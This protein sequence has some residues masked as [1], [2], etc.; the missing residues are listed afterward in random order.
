MQTRATTCGRMALLLGFSLCQGGCFAFLAEDDDSE[1]EVYGPTAC[2]W[3]E[4]DQPPTMTLHAVSSTGT[5]SEP[6][7]VRVEVE[8]DA[9]TAVDLAQIRLSLEVHTGQAQPGE[10]VSF[11]LDGVALE[12]ALLGGS[13]GNSAEL[14]ALVPAER[15][16]DGCTLTFLVTGPEPKTIPIP[17]A[18]SGEV[19]LELQDEVTGCPGFPTL[20]AN[21]ALSY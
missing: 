4:A 2:R 8:V 20:V 10:A 17:I 14:V 12:G 3:T 9:N 6:G 5:A 1:V 15:C 7:Q 11:S 16:V 18:V 21:D 13:L 19:T